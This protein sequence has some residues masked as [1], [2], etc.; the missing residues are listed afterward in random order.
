MLDKFMQG[1]KEKY[2]EIDADPHGP[3]KALK[4]LKEKYDIDITWSENTQKT[5][6]RFGL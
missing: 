6:D 5:I 4:L 1:T 2:D 3:S